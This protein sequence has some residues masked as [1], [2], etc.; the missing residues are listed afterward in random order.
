MSYAYSSY[1]VQG[2]ADLDAAARSLVESRVASVAYVADGSAFWLKDGKLRTEKADLQWREHE[3]HAHIKLPDDIEGLAADGLARALLHRFSEKRVHSP[4]RGPHDEYLRAVLEP[5]LLGFDE[6]R[7]LLLPM[8]K[9]YKSGVFII[10]FDVDTAESDIGVAEFVTKYGNLFERWCDEAWVP[11]AIAR[12]G[13]TTVLHEGGET[14]TDRKTNLGLV[15]IHRAAA[16]A[17]AETVEIGDQRFT[18]FPVHRPLGDFL[19]T[20]LP[21]N[22]GS[23]PGLV[24]EEN[25][26]IAA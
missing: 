7:L 6:G 24:G 12:I 1:Y 23:P 2:I 16:D 5:V 10:T 20:L 3:A 14:R 8:V 17:M 25:A 22:S 18:M 21:K 26:R 19:D 11:H 15:M 13:A 4:L 9:L